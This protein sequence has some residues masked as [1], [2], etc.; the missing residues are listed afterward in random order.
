M[1]KNDKILCVWDEHAKEAYGCVM[2]D[3]SASAEN[4]EPALL[5]ML[6]VN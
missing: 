5:G 1:V 3:T 6:S 2:C 4:G